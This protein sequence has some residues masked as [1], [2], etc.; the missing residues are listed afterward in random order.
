M[1]LQDNMSGLSLLLILKVKVIAE[2]IILLVLLYHSLETTS[3]VT[4]EQ[5]P[6]K[7]TYYTLMILSGV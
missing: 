1:A 6:S 3:S 4:V 7:D 5:T 2:V